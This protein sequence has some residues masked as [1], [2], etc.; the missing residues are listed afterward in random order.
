METTQ[1]NSLCS[2]LYPKPGKTIIFVFLSFIFFSSSG[3]AGVEVEITTGGR[4]EV[5]GKGVGE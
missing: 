5:A 1:G 2:Y 3:S 4:E